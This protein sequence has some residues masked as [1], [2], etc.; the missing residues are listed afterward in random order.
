MAFH[1][2]SFKWTVGCEPPGKGI[3]LRY[4]YVVYWDTHKPEAFW[5]MSWLRSLERH[6]RYEAPKEVLQR[7]SFLR[8]LWF[9]PEIFCCAKRMHSWPLLECFS[10]NE[11]MFHTFSCWLLFL[12]WR[13]S[14]WA[15]E[16][17]SL[18]SRSS[19][20]LL[21]TWWWSWLPRGCSC[22]L[23]SVIVKMPH[24]HTHTHSSESTLVEWGHRHAISGFKSM[25]TPA[26]G[27]YQAHL[28]SLLN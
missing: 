27:I 4:L 22:Q 1:F 17:T 3:W 2:L 6:R 25:L 8:L 9:Y 24:T 19:S 28:Y 21:T 13:V 23:F 15:C 11:L 26:G 10:V 14:T 12:F 5:M 18:N 7:A 20:L 16:S